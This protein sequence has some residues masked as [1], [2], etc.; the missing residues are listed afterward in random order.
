MEIKPPKDTDQKIPQVP[1][2][3]AGV[4]PKHPFRMLVVGPS[5]SGKSVVIS[6][7]L[8]RVYN[9]Y[10][11]RV[12]IFSPTAKRDPAYKGI[13]KQRDFKAE[14]DPADL[15]HLFQTQKNKV[16]SQGKAK[17]PRML[18]LFDD[19]I[20]DTKFMNKKEFMQSFFQS[21][22][23]N[24]SIM[25]AA[26]SYMRVPRSP[27]LN[28][29][30]VIMF[31]S[32]ESEIER[33]SKE[34]CPPHTKC[35]DFEQIVRHATKDQFDFLYINTRAPQGEKFRKK[36][37]VYLNLDDGTGTLPNEVGVPQVSRKRNR[38]PDDEA[39]VMED[40]KLAAPEPSDTADP[41]SNF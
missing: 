17:A 34:Y 3:D 26:Q 10:F 38:D 30:D 21:R 16:K 2:A 7:L 24:I 20:S 5:G 15:K 9:G 32:S 35:R 37:D 28:A 36:F 18:I 22:H 14:F 41:V 6:H 29:T 31:P 8:R 27:R 19:V 13:T 23:D 11:E 1:H 12:V 39:S 33:I 40:S 25:L 4:V